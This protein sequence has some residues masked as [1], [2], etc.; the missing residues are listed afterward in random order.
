MASDID[1]SD[2]LTLDMAKMSLRTFILPIMRVRTFIIDKMKVHILIMCKMK[3]RTL[4]I[5][6]MKYVVPSLWVKC[7]YQIIFFAVYVAI[8]LNYSKWRDFWP[9]PL[10]SVLYPYTLLRPQHSAL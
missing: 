4:V 10:P 3:V 6:K 8:I 7:G 9:P 1:S 2:S 5:G